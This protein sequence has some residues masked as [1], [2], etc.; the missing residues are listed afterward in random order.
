MDFKEWLTHGRGEQ[1]YTK[2]Q[3]DIWVKKYQHSGEDFNKWVE[4][5]SGGDNEVAK[6]IKDRKFLFAGRILATRGIDRTA[7]YSN[8]YVIAPPKD[9]IKG[10]YNTAYEIAQTLAYGG[11]VG[12]DIGTLRPSGAPVANQA[13]TTSG[14][15][16]FLE[17]YAM[18]SQ[19]IGQHGRRGALMVSMPVWHPDVYD[20]ITLKQDTSKATKANLSLRVDNDFFNAVRTG[21]KTPIKF[22][23]ETG[24]KQYTYEKLVDCKKVFESVCKI[25][26]ETAEIGMLYWDN[27]INYSI[28]DKHPNFAYA[29]V[30]PCAEQPL[31][32]YGSCLLGSLNI[33]AFVCHGGMVDFVELANATRIATKALNDVQDE[34]IDRHPLPQNKA[35]VEQWRQ[36]GLGVMGLADAML[37]CGVAYG[38]LAAEIFIDKIFKTILQNAFLESA[39]LGKARGNFGEFDAHAIKESTFY[40]CNKQLLDD[41]DGKHLRNSQILTIAPTGTISTM[42]GVSGGIEPLFATHYT[43]KTES[44]HGCDKYYKVVTPIIAELFGDSETLPSF[45]V[46]AH[47][48]HY[49]NRIDIQA[50]A[51]RYIDASISSTINLPNNAT[52]KNIAD[53]YMLGHKAGLKGVTVYR[54]GCYRDGILTVDKLPDTTTYDKPCPSCEV[55]VINS[56]GCSICL[57]CGYSQCG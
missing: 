7:T 22:T 36:I 35:C 54:D 28:V 40:K 44:L 24:G 41:W 57:S 18:T 26:W 53:L 16:S 49:K 5:V 2:L 39:R 23:Y 13:K 17:L 42:L 20:F 52:Q 11:G 19:I 47:D 25:A 45:V 46:T 6:L 4:R 43:R 3:E 48:I 12:V 33:S 1:Y 10:I 21:K 27:I 34:G 15:V 32:A 38:S 29:G 14:A 30:N 56:G 37:K 50:A 51:Q 31:P 9:S 55:G 8:C